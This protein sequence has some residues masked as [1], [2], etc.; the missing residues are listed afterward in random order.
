LVLCPKKE[1]HLK[2]G[3]PPGWGDRWGLV[4]QDRESR[5]VVSHASG[6][7]EEALVAEALRKAHAVGGGNR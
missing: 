7:G 1:R 6:R 3:E 5:L 4:I 2:A